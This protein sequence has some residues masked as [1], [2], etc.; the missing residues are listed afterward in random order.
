M[1]RLDFREL[2]YTAMKNNNH[3][4]LLPGHCLPGAL[5]IFLLMVK[6]FPVSASPDPG[7]A[8]GDRTVTEIKSADLTTLQSIRRY[9]SARANYPTS[10]IQ[11]G[12]EGLVEL[13]ARVSHQGVIT[14][15]HNHQPNGHFHEVDEILVQARPPSGVNITVSTRHE[16]LICEARRVISM[17]PALDM[18]DL[19]G[20]ML[21]FSFRF[22]FTPDD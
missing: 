3:N 14:E 5:L 19:F 8:V 15:I 1:S 20:G 13:Y 9:A 16:E 21:K 10:A 12:Q 11:A 2:K 17:L 6:P 7:K 22:A 18:P 4:R